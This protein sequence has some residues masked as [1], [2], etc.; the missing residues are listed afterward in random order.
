MDTLLRPVSTNTITTANLPEESK[1]NTNISGYDPEAPIDIAETGGRDILLESLGIDENPKAMPEAD[2]NNA[3]EVKQY[4]LDIINKSGDSPTMGA[5]QRTLNDI[6]A[7]M[8]LCIDADPSTILDRIGGVLKAWKSLV[9]IKDAHQKKSILY[10]LMRA[11]DSKE[12]NRI[13]FEKMNEMK[14]WQ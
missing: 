1:D 2:R 7:D 3:K 12:M 6:K 14:I 8:G 4:I 13:V 9:F 10:K 11:P 5:F